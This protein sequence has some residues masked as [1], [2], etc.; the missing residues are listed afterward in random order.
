MV[1]PDFGDVLAEERATEHAPRF[2]DFSTALQFFH[3]WPAHRKAAR[4]ILVRRAEIN[5][6]HYYL[7]DPV[8]HWLEGSYPSAA[9][10]AATPAT[11]TTAGASLRS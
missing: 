10:A 7:P 4:L 6:N 8:A 9:F 1:L 5:G 2:G 3:A 11:S